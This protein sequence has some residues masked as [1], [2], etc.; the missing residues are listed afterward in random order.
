KNAALVYLSLLDEPAARERPLV[1]LR[2]ADNMSDASAALSVLASVDGPERDQALAEF[3]GRWRHDP[4]VLDK[5]F[6]VQATSSLPDTLARV[7][8]LTKHADFTL[9]N[10]NRVRALVGAFAMSNQA[11]FHAKDGSGYAFLTDLVLD[12]DALN[13]QV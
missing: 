13:P 4:L 3:Y 6:T 1:Q 5:W 7:R 10:P 12:L 9:K 11:R 8:E 2:K